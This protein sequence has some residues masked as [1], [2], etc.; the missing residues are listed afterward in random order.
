MFT[1]TLTDV[2]RKVGEQIMT[3][4]LVGATVELIGWTLAMV[5]P[6]VKSIPSQIATGA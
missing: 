6:V 1:V 2:M 3:D 4:A 5:D